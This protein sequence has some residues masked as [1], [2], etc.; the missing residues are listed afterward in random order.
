MAHGKTA[1]PIPSRADFFVSVWVFLPPMKET[2]K[3]LSSS[4]DKYKPEAVQS[5]IMKTE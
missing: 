2:K 1:I 3:N 4:T 5:C